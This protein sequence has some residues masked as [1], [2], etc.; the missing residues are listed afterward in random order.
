M[1]LWVTGSSRPLQGPRFQNRSIP[2]PHRHPDLA[3][4]VPSSWRRARGKLGLN[5]WPEKG[6]PWPWP[7]LSRAE[8][9]HAFRCG[10]QGLWLGRTKVMLLLRSSG[11]RQKPRGPS[12][13]LIRLI[14][15]AIVSEAHLPG[16]V[17]IHWVTWDR[18]LQSLGQ[19]LRQRT[20]KEFYL[21]FTF[22][23]TG[24][25]R[26]RDAGSFQHQPR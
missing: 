6:Q 15:E 24:T 8:K 17:L 14:A 2:P 23:V 18:A 21:L 26:C 25:I 20:W 4:L 13:E 7:R 5:S 10:P 22:G 9:T 1:V 16:L 3:G 11:G 19:F 12:T